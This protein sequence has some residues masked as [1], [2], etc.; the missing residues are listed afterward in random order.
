MVGATL[1]RR[2]EKADFFRTRDGRQVVRLY[3]GTANVRDAA[4]QWVPVDRNLVA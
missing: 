3:A 4:G 1:L 2:E